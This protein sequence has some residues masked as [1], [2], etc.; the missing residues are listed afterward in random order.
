MCSH[1]LHS[2]LCYLISSQPAKE[3]LWCMAEIN[4]TYSGYIALDVARREDWWLECPIPVRN[5]VITCRADLQ[6]RE[7]AAG[8]IHGGP[9]QLGLQLGILYLLRWFISKFPTQLTQCC[10]SHAN[11][12]PA[13]ACTSQFTDLLPQSIPTQS[14]DLTTMRGFVGAGRSSVSSNTTVDL[15]MDIN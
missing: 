4:A 15:D 2:P 11:Y 14:N 8:A 1:S 6:G 5:I 10:M 9:W 3:E 12:T 13:C 7:G